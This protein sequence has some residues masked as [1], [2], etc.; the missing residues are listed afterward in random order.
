M[1]HSAVGHA[2]TPF[3][4]LL[5][6]RPLHWPRSSMGALLTTIYVFILSFM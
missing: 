3:D 5:A 1:E 4:Q 6:A 2:L